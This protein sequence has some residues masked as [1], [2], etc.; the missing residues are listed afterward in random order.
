M[1]KTN[2]NFSLA[3]KPVSGK[4]GTNSNTKTKETHNLDA[5]TSSNGFEKKRKKMLH[6]NMPAY[7][8]F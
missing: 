1:S 8:L 2:T 6:H 7:Q 4:M 5:Q 3:G